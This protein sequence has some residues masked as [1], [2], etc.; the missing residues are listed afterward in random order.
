MHILISVNDSIK[1]AME[2][3]EELAKW[4]DDRGI[5]SQIITSGDMPLHTEKTRHLFSFMQNV[6]LVV[7]LGGDG[8]MLATTQTLFEKAVPMVGFNFG[9]LGFLTSARSEQLF[10]GMQDVLDGK[11][12]KK[13]RGALRIR[14]TGDDGKSVDCHALNELALTRGHYG[15]ML[16][17]NTLINGEPLAESRADGIIVSSPSGSTAYALSAGGPIVSPEIDCMIIVSLAPHSLVSRA[18]LASGDDTVTILP[19][20]GSHVE[21]GLFVDGHNIEMSSDPKQIEVTTVPNAIEILGYANKSFSAA[22][23]NAFFGGSNAI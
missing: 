23:A 8:T 14:I 18:F 10:T 12:V 13:P 1:L 22:A 17:F 4:L 20:N 15:R 7:T 11:M 5:T 6:D 9:T 16:R 3:S 19:K 21:C 2:K